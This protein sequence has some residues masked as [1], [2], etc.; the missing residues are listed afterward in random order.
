[1]TLLG[2]FQMYHL[3]LLAHGKTLIIVCNKPDI[4][5]IDIDIIIIFPPIS[6]LFAIAVSPVSLQILTANSVKKAIPV[7][8]IK[9]PKNSLFIAVLLDKLFNKSIIAEILGR[10]ITIIIAPAIKE[11]YITYSGLYC[12]N[13]R[14]IIK[15]IK[16]TPYN[17]YNV[18]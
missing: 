12:F 17:F 18:H 13:I 16:P 11:T 5:G 3:S 10:I 7:I 4:I 15:L 8:F 6:T 14:I 9:R 2:R 1:M